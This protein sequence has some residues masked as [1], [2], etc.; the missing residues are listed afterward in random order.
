[1]RGGQKGG[2]GGGE[3]KGQVQRQEPAGHIMQLAAL[4]YD[5]FPLKQLS[6]LNWQSLAMSQKA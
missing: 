3:V 1:M 4:I 5:Y 2:L 6:V